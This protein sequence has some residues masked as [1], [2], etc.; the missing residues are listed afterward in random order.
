M[1][2]TVNTAEPISDLDKSIL[3]TLIG[4][5]DVEPRSEPAT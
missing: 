4:I 2:I 3:T 1:H 5:V